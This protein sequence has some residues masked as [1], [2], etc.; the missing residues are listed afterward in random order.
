MGKTTRHNFLLQNIQ[1][2]FCLGAVALLAINANGA[3]D[4]RLPK[5]QCYLVVSSQPSLAM[6]ERY[7]NNNPLYNYNIFLAQN[8]WYAL[9]LKPITHQQ[10]YKLKQNPAIAADAF[11]SQGQYFTQYMAKEENTINRYANIAQAAEAGDLKAVMTFIENGTDI[12]K[13]DNGHNSALIKASKFGYLSIVAYLLEKNANVNLLNFSGYTALMEAV[14]NGHT[15]I[16]ALLI[17]SGADVNIKGYSN[18][19]A[20][21]IAAKDWHFELV[22]LLI[23]NGADINAQDNLG[24]APL[25]YAIS[26]GFTDGAIMLMDKGA[27][28]NTANIHGYTPLMN[29]AWYGNEQLVRLLIEKGAD[30]NAQD[31]LGNTAFNKVLSSSPERI[32][33]IV[34]ILVE[35]GGDINAKDNEGNTALFYAKKWI[36]K[37][38]AKIL[39]EFGAN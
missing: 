23:E 12:N 14:T 20:L 37:D 38:K 24:N 6:A 2:L 22:P 17:Y 28:V 33:E 27:D 19:T 32:K 34:A 9:T 39:E 36:N 21:M 4:Y 1:N 5:G 25:T 31:N 26:Q 3:E 30:V 13:I 8:G 18:I 7:I 29:A 16:A 35:N 15:A 10:A 11:C